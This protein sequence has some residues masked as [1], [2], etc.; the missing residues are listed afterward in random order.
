[1]KKIKFNFLKK[2]EKDKKVNEKKKKKK[3]ISV[4]NVI[5]KII[6][7]TMLILMIG[8]VVVGILAI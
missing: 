1:M 4:R 7:Y 2:K 5:S 6:V 3:K 8:S